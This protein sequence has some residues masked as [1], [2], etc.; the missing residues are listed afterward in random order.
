M[1]RLLMVEKAGCSQL[2]GCAWRT[3]ELLVVSD[4]A[5]SISRNP[6]DGT[7]GSHLEQQREGSVAACGRPGT[8]GKE[9]GAGTVAH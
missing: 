1:P 4:W 3:F 5:G 7:A 2:M 6:F 8:G 9:V